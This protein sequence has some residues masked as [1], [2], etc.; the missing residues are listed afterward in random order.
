MTCFCGC[1]EFDKNPKTL[2]TELIKSGGF[3]I[4]KIT[5]ISGIS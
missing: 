5:G 2:W 4:F 1:E 3:D